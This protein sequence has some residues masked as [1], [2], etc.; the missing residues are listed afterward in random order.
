MQPSQIASAIG[1]LTKTNSAQWLV[2][3]QRTYVLDARSFFAGAM[4]S[5]K[6]FSGIKGTTVGGTLLVMR[7]MTP[8]SPIVD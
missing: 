8:P 3:D 1:G 2:T 7:P 4:L 5:K 6:G